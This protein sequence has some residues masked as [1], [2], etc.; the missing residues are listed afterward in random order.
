MTYLLLLIL[1][2]APQAN[3]PRGDPSRQ[4]SRRLL[5]LGYPRPAQILSDD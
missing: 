3:H 4:R 5:S 1:L 2:F